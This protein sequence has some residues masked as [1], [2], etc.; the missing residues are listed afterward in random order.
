MN[1]LPLW[2][3]G[4]FNQ[5]SGPPPS[6]HSQTSIIHMRNKSTQTY[7]APSSPLCVR[8]MKGQ[9]RLARAFTARS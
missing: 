5:P 9:G 1:E 8:Q 6:F 3:L 4:H 2:H 7:S